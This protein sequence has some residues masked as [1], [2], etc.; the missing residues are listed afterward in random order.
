MRAGQAA[1]ASVDVSTAHSIASLVLRRSNPGDPQTAS[2]ASL[3]RGPENDCREHPREAR[4][5]RSSFHR[6]NCLCYT[7]ANAAR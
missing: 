1:L 3:A 6:R 5:D 2:E 4:G 7:R